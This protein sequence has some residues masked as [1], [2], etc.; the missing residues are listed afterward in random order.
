MRAVAQAAVVVLLVLAPA[1]ASLLVLLIAMA[2]LWVFI[3]FISIGLHL[4]SM[5]R[6]VV[7]LLLGALLLVVGL[8][9]F[10][11]LTG[12]SGLGVSLNV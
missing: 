1:V 3:N 9:F 7:V 10:L 4:E 12:L 11:S 5:T 6:A 8:S 2:T